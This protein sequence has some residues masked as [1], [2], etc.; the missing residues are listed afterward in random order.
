MNKKNPQNVHTIKVNIIVTSVEE[1]DFV[2][3]RSVVIDVKSVKGKG[4]ASTVEKKTFVLIVEAKM[5]VITLS[6]EIDV[7]TVEAVF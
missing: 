6:F 7:S 4:Y 3:I 5:F 2:N 1:K